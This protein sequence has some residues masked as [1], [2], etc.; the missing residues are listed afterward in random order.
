MWLHKY[1]FV[2]VCVFQKKKTNISGSKREVGMRGMCLFLLFVV[3][4][5]THPSLYFYM[6]SNIF[7]NI[8]TLILISIE[9]HN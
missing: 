7:M 4:N 2:C 9:P 8:N 3:L 6:G 1:T 5:K